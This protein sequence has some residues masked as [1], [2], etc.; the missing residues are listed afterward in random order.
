M[1]LYTPVG[2]GAPEEEATVRAGQAGWSGEG[3]LAERFWGA[4]ARP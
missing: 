3:G 1:F 4:A 2:A